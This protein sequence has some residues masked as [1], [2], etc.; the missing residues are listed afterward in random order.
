MLFE[1]IESYI[2]HI[3]YTGTKNYNNTNNSILTTGEIQTTYIHKKYNNTPTQ[4]SSTT[5]DE[6]HINIRERKK[7][8]YINSIK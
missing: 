7:H 3:N 4:R 6:E 1:L 8:D 5:I 2:L